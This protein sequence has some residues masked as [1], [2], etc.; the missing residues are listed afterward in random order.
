MVENM[1][2]ARS[3]LSN[4]SSSLSFQQVSELNSRKDVI[5]EE[6]VSY[7]EEH[8][9]L[10]HLMSDFMSQ[11]LLV[12]PDDVEA[13]AKDYFAGYLP[14]DGT[15]A[16]APLILCGPSGVGKG[17]LLNRLRQEYGHAIALSVSHTTRDPR[18]GEKDGFHYH[19]TDHESMQ[20]DI[21]QG[22][23][24]EFAHVHGNIYGTSVQSVKDVSST[25]KICILEIDIQGVKTVKKTTL[26]PF[27]VYVAPPSPEALEKRLRDRATETPEALSTRLENA[28]EEMAWLEAPGNADV[29]IVN[30]DLEAAYQELLTQLQTWYP[31]VFVEEGVLDEEDVDPEAKA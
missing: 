4:S 20:A 26:K 5:K 24:I 2:S 27:C 29:K 25:G 13:F 19:F 9:E 30:D 3:G 31:T 11:V 14:S 10:K 15:P 7:I 22:R 28:R 6:H 12:K 1:N 16:H 21:E 17:T 23:F 8:P 18:D